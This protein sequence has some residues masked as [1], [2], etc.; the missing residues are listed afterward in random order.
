L[1]VG[2]CLVV[3]GWVFSTTG[4]KMMRGGWVHSKLQYFALPASAFV[5]RY[6][7]R[8]TTTMCAIALL[9]RGG[10]TRVVL[11]KPLGSSLHY[12]YMLRM[13]RLFET[14]GV[15]GVA[16]SGF[17]CATGYWYS[18]IPWKARGP[19]LL[20]RWGWES[21]ILGSTKHS[22]RHSKRNK[23]RGNAQAAKK[24]TRVH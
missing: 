14:I 22:T 4:N 1:V 21:G 20:Y 24:R 7:V 11:Q 9:D 15:R 16:S 18:R 17:C 5:A 19:M 6:A 13:R 8:R 12:S 10:E 23:S 2:S 3:S